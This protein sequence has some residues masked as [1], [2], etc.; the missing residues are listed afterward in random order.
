MMAGTYRCMFRAL[1]LDAFAAS[2]DWNEGSTRDFH[3]P[4]FRL[5]PILS[6]LFMA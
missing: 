1:V 3:V 5:G 4:A 6:G 2:C